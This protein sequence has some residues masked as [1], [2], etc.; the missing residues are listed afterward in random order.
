V[1]SFGPTPLIYEGGKGA[2]C[3]DIHPD[4]AVHVLEHDQWGSTYYDYQ[5]NGSMGRMIA[6]TGSGQREMVFM[7]LP[8]APF[9]PAHPRFVDYN[10]KSPGVLGAWCGQKDVDGGTNINAGYVTIAAM[11]N[12]REAI[13]YHKTGSDEP[14]GT[15]LA[16]GDTGYV[17]SGDNS[18][19]GHWDIP[20]SL[21][22]ANAG[23]W[24]KIGIVYDASVDT[25]YMHIVMSEGK[26]SGGDQKLGYVRCHLIA[27]DTLLCE[28]PTGQDPAITSPIK[29]PVATRIHRMIGWFGE[30]PTTPGSYPNTISVIAVTS[31][32]S[33]KIALVFTNKRQSGTGQ[34]NN[35]VSYVESDSNGNEWFRPGNWPPTIANGMLHYVTNYATGDAERA[36]TDVSA[37][38][39]YKDHLHVVWNGCWYDSAGGSISNQANIN[40][41]KDTDP[42]GKFSVVAPG[43]WTGTAPG[44]WCRNVCKMSISAKDPIYHP[45]PP[46]NDSV[47]LFV[48]WT[49]F[50]GYNMHNVE[51]SLDVSK[52]D[53]SNGEIYAAV[54]ND[55]GRTW[56]S[57]FNLTGTYT[58]DCDSAFCLSEHWSSLAE[59]MYDGDLHLEYVCDKAAGG[60]IQETSTPWTLNPMMYMHIKQ[61]PCPKNCGEA[62]ANQDPPSW[63]IPPIKVSPTGSRTI[64]F[65]LKGIYNL[66]G[67]YV[68][69][70]LTGPVKCIGN[71]TGSLQP[72]NDNLVSISVSCS[73]QGFIHDSVIVTTCQGSGDEKTIKMPIYAVCSDDYYECKRDAKT[74]FR[75]DNDV[76]SLWVC[77]NTEERVWDKRLPDDSDQ[78]IMSAGVI[79][80][81]MSG[82]TP[83]IGRQ[84]YTDTRSGARDTIKTMRG[85]IAA[86]SD[87]DVQKIQATKTYIWYP[88]DVI[89]GDPNWYWIN[90]NKQIIV[91]YN[92]PG[93]TCLEWKKDQVIK[94][95]WINWG[96][97]PAWWPSPDAYTGHPDIYYGVYADLDAPY[98][99][100]CRVAGGETQS[101]CNT[102]GWED[103]N[104]IVWQHGFTSNPAQHTPLYEKYYLG[105]A[106]TNT[107]GGIVTPVGCKDVRNTQY[108]YP[109]AGWGWQDS[110]LYRLATT[111][112]SAATVVDNPDSVVDRS[113]VMTAGKIPAGGANDTTFTGEFILIEALLPNSTLD[114]LKTHIIN[115]RGQLIVR[116]AKANVFSKDWPTVKCGDVNND[117]VITSADIVYLIN[118]LFITGPTPAFPS[119]RADANGDH[120]IT[121][122]DC[123]YLINY[124]FLHG[125][126]PNCAEL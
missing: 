86:E 31:P 19:G 112:F 84:D 65:H 27:G 125:P 11:H 79:A 38:Y 76:E 24:P 101:A 106:L 22:G 56:T 29:V 63:T 8:V 26:T 13:I 83:I 43:Y 72:G 85:Y 20:D 30:V 70:P 123:V 94:H 119:A 57:P 34:Y 48:T 93:H 96:R 64:S 90:I 12:G 40:H 37:C 4:T 104:K 23:E 6:V 113:V 118:Y 33:K 54:S 49:Q 46:N 2:D 111:S 71:C 36:Y 110:Q 66:G 25:D 42:V 9:T 21:G 121:A 69:T 59:N 17:C 62:F 41:W 120:N 10:C 45:N 117:G 81:F 61:L 75:P 108:L 99:S 47:Y 32:V 91:F 74:Q 51:E 14:W 95:V 44:S 73:G 68:V 55:S 60:A 67:S 28:T 1:P 114:A 105:M 116:L 89:P 92:R 80:A 122:A 109:N 103:V 5:K 52:K 100:S 15:S 77:A 126:L 7:Y 53:Y 97:Y 3:F 98:D 102:A 107:S 50:N 82:G 58:P 18:F 124:L 87:C 115:T 88:P 39:D 78:V 35:D 16:L